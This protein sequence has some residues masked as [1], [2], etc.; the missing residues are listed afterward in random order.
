MNGMI[1]EIWEGTLCASR[2]F[3]KADKKHETYIRMETHINRLLQIIPKEQHNEL[4]MLLSCRDEME[5]V[6]IEKAFTLGYKTGAKITA[7]ALLT[8]E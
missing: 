2:H 1:K 7:E 6:S 3:N 8:K 4:S 5:Q